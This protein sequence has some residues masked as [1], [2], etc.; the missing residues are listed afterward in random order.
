M[1]HDKNATFLV[2]FIVGIVKTI[3]ELLEADRFDILSEDTE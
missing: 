2:K 3:M 1:Q